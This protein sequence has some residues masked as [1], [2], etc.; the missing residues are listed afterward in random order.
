MAGGADG[1]ERSVGRVGVVAVAFA[2]VVGVGQ[3]DLHERVEHRFDLGVVGRDEPG[4][5]L[6]VTLG[7]LADPPAAPPSQP[8][9]T[10]RFVLGASETPA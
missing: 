9:V 8:G 4:P 5:Y 1:A 6:G 10:D 3:A 7:A 2:T